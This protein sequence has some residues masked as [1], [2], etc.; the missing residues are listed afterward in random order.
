MPV[1]AALLF[2]QFG[3]SA[4]ASALEINAADEQAKAIEFAAD[5]EATNARIRNNNRQQQL[6][7]ILA[8]NNAALGARG[9]SGGG[10]QRT[11]M[12]EN[13]RRASKAA[14]A[15]LLGAR[16]SELSLR[17][18]ASAARVNSRLRAMTSLLG[19]GAEIAKTGF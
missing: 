19:T 17:A 11:I 7:E 5:Q 14:E 8:A 1:P 10:S 3:L 6:L 18:R 2:G 15:D 9:V 16:S 12:Q 13:M 4:A